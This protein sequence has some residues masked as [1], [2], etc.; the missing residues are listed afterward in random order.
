MKQLDVWYDG[1]LSAVLS[2]KDGQFFL[3]PVEGGHDL[4][5]AMSF[6]SYDAADAWQVLPPILSQSLPE[7]VMYETVSNTIKKLRIDDDWN[8]DIDILS[9][10]GRNQV[11]LI[12]ISNRG[13]PLER[14]H[15]DAPELFDHVLHGDNNKSI[16][17]E[18][19]SRFS[20]NSGISG[21]NA[22]VLA[23]D[24]SK[25]TLP[26]ER[27]IVKF[28]TP[29]FPGIAIN[30]FFCL[31][32]SKLSGLDTVEAVLS[33]DGQRLI[34]DR[35]DIHEELGQLGFEELCTLQGK[36][37]QGK[38]SGSYEDGFTTLI[39]QVSP[40]EVFR[41]KA[42][43]FKSIVLMTVIQ[44]GDAHLKNFGLLYDPKK[45]YIRLA[46]FY[47][48]VTTTVY[49]PHDQP[50]LS[51]RDEKKWPT[52]AEI[53]EFGLSM[54]LRKKA[55]QVLIDDVEIGVGHAIAEAMNYAE[56][57]PENSEVITKVTD[58]W[59]SSDVVKLDRVIDTKL[60]A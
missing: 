16:L 17:S 46:P 34:I 57:H 48:M 24:I 29:E 54:G 31:R 12:Q 27:Q 3:T 21:V 26:F 7:G 45:E 1:I 32:A 41:T 28:T 53:I 58:K 55:I 2:Y 42:D 51:L 20:L 15:N 25:L 43:L 11:G 49:I 52:K 14:S 56:I 9:Y 38:Y 35:F 8:T 33:D 5:L 60:S 19:L 47:D 6:S 10:T 59:R 23:D 39:R 22:K 13:E 44:N 37:S 18:C 40:K 36:P 50:A 4:S 30:E